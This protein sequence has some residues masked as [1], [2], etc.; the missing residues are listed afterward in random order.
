M[1]A[2][3]APPLPASRGRTAVDEEEPDVK[4]G[5]GALRDIQRLL[6]IATRDHVG[7]DPGARSELA[8]PHATVPP[9]L[10]DA[11][12]FLWQVRCYLHLLAGRTQD[13][14]LRELQPLVARRLGLG[15]GPD[16]GVAEL[17]ARHRAYT[18]SVRAL[19]TAP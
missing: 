4:R 16:T 18:H 1:A 15:R 8:G 17:M 14:L 9:A 3:V 11:R 6:W 5:P 13:R 10:A 7:A 12:R 19:L 2:A